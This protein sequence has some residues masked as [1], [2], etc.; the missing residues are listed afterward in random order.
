MKQVKQDVRHFLKGIAIG[1]IAVIAF[2]SGKCHAQSETETLREITKGYI[3][4]IDSMSQL[5]S[6]Q[7]LEIREMVNTIEDI[8]EWQQQDMEKGETNMG[9]HS[10]GWGSNYW[11]TEM[12]NDLN[13]KLNTN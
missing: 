5:I 12:V 3:T 2:N 8:L 9:S 1:T 4:T 7:E 13:N 11:L 10:E 6:F